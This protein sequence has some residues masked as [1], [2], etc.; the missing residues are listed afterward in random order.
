MG[1]FNRTQNE[2]QAERAQRS[3][4]EARLQAPT[5]TE[6]TE[7]DVSDNEALAQLQQ[8][9]AALTGMLTEQTQKDARTA[10]LDKYPEVKP[11][12]GFITG[13]ESVEEYTALV[14]Q[15]STAIKS[16]SGDTAPVTEVTDPAAG[17]DTTPATD[18]PAT[19]PAPQTPVTTGGT[20]FSGEA[21][22]E[23]KVTDAIQKGDFQSYFRAKTEAAEAA[24]VG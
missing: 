16:A 9:V 14:E 1:R 4:L 6:E 8:Q 3:E 18:A 19:E 17:V 22:L 2:L 20:T 11:L 23:E 10:V 24:V 5:T 12:A 15:L 13:A 21:A 7:P